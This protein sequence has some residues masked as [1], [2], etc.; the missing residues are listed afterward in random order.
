MTFVR[1]LPTS[2][3]KAMQVIPVKQVVD[4]SIERALD[5]YFKLQGDSL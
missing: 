1:S 5:I 3:A 2:F 4:L